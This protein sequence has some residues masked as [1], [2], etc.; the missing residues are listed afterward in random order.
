MHLI[1][2]PIPFPWE[3]H[4]THGIPVF[5]IPM[6]TSISLIVSL[7]LSRV[8]YGNATLVGVPVYAISRLQSALNAAARLVFSL[9]KYDSVTLL[10]QE[11][12]WLK[13][14]QQSAA[15]STS[16][17]FSFTTVSMALR[18]R[19]SPTTSVCRRPRYAAAPAL[20]VNTCSRSSSIA[21]VHCR[22]PCVSRDRDVSVEQSV[23]FRH[24]V[25]VAA[26][27]QVTPEDCRPTVREKLLNT[28]CF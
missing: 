17:L 12:H 11:L 22:R 24:G 28:G 18:H 19:T 10:L 14:E 13:I 5:P 8:D 26:H 9:Q 15:L 4:G 7:V 16:S 23:R 3:S 25:N 1:P 27:V 2:I 6:H 21:A 20:G